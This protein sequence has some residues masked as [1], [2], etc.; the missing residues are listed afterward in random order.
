MNT[1]LNDFFS[2]ASRIQSKLIEDREQFELALIQSIPLSSAKINKA[3]ELV[4]DVWLNDIKGEW[5]NSEKENLLK[6]VQW[7]S[8]IKYHDGKYEITFPIPTKDE[9]E[10]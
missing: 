6:A 1:T 2:R 9:K 7:I 10:V 8:D 3:N 5:K 4:V